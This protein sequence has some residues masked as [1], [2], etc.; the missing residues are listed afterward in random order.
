MLLDLKNCKI[1]DI[2]QKNSRTPLIEIAKKTKLSVDT[3]KKRIQKMLKEGIFYSRIQL[4]P[5]HF[6]FPCIVEIFVKFQN[7]GKKLDEFLDF[8]KRHPRV[9]ELL[10]FSG[11]WDCRITL[12]AKDLDD[13]TKICSNIKRKFANVIKDWN[14]CITTKVYKF[15]IYDTLGLL[16]E[17][18]WR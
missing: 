13:M 11:V 3:V 6:G 8:L 15:E 12:I 5:R 1:L 2:L 18:D 9:T 14:E 17:N 16:K 4:R 10:T 7:Y